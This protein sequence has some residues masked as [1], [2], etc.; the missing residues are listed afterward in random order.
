MKR[1]PRLKILET[2][3]DHDGSVRGLTVGEEIKIARKYRPGRRICWKHAVQIS[4]LTNDRQ[5]ARL[6][7]EIYMRDIR[8]NNLP[9]QRG[10]SIEI[11]ARDRLKL[12]ISE[13]LCS[14]RRSV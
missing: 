13:N 11:I 5:A 12:G 4:F 3:G 10:A 2:G 7:G 8:T 6:V 9:R 1:F 14:W